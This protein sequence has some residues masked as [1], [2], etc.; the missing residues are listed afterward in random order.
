MAKVKNFSSWAKVDLTFSQKFTANVF[1]QCYK[2]SSIII[3]TLFCRCNDNESTSQ[4]EA[5]NQTQPT[6]PKGEKFSMESFVS[7]P[8][9]SLN[10]SFF[11]A[12]FG[13]LMCYHQTRALFWQGVI[14][15]NFHFAEMNFH[16]FFARGI[17]TLPPAHLQTVF[18][19]SA[20]AAFF[21]GIGFKYRASCGTFLVTYTYLFLLEKSRYNNHYY[22][23]ILIALFFLITDAHKR[24]SVDSMLS[25][26]SSWN[27]TQES[28]I[29]S[30]VPYWNILIFRF[31]LFIVYFYS[32]IAKLN[33]D[34]SI[35]FEPMTL[36]SA[37]ERFA[38]FR[39]AAK[40]ILPETEVLSCLG[41]FFSIGGLFYDLSVG[42]FLLSPTLL[43]LGLSM[44][45][46]FHLSNHFL[47]RIG[48]FPWV[49][50]A[51]NILFLNPET[52]SQYIVSACKKVK[53]IF[54]KSSAINADDASPGHK[55]NQQKP[56]MPKL[57]KG[58]LMTYFVLQLLIPFRHWLYPGN[59]NWTMEG[60]QFS[61]RM[62]LNEE[63]VIMRLDVETKTRNYTFKWVKQQIKIS[64]HWSSNAI[65]S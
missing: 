41:C 50:M 10:L 12:A 3:L 18:A 42:F 60:H 7:Q 45:M 55:N 40:L 61:W 8:V 26:L 63:A 54:T 44:S 13:F 56:R 11:R 5:T 48:T 27:S 49:M 9:N 39:Q 22:L 1:V 21:M 58:F 62:M 59:V 24:L 28:Q 34:W 51:S 2:N 36:W 23:Y 32:G 19:I 53:G 4:D 43:P 16:Y 38:S 17:P 33:Y 35:R 14:E 46:F 20:I 31:Q 52:P 25:R 57:L 15:A 30:R 65:G 47:F 64:L 29:D 37:G 6:P